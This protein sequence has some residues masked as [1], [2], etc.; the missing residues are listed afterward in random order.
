MQDGKIVGRD[1]VINTPDAKLEASPRGASVSPVETRTPWS[2][3]P[4]E[5]ERTSQVF[6]KD[7]SGLSG[8]GASNECCYAGLTV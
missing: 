3:N 1:I 4:S 6:I 8:G 2:Q 7:L 5:L